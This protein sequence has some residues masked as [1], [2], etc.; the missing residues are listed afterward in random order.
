MGNP[1][2]FTR[3]S[4]TL[5]EITIAL[6]ANGSILFIPV[7]GSW[8]I[9]YGWDGINNGNNVNEGK[10]KIYGGDIRVPAVSRTYKIS[11]DFQSGYF[12]I[13]PQ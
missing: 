9:S 13:T 11:V 8:D 12:N 4:N 3:V 7:A 2:V 10:L 5:Y 6:I 1:R